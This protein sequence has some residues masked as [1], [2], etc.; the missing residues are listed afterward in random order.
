[1]RR[2]LGL[3]LAQNKP[4]LV[5]NTTAGALEVHRTVQ[6]APNTAFS[7]DMALKKVPGKQAVAD[8]TAVVCTVPDTGLELDSTAVVVPRTLVP[9]RILGTVAD[10]PRW[11]LSRRRRSSWSTSCSSCSLGLIVL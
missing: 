11:V 2:K 1:M 10:G 7:V 5:V 9:S 8:C 3:V 4:G 6:K